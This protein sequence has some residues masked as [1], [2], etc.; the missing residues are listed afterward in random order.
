MFD[1]EELLELIEL[2]DLLVLTELLDLLELIE[3]LDLLELIEL[4][5]RLELLALDGLVV[6]INSLATA[7]NKGCTGGLL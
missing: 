7:F 4:L 3:L 1:D 2:L 6:P 5:D